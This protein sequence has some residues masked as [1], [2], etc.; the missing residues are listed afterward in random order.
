MSETTSFEYKIQ[1]DYYGDYYCLANE[2]PD[3]CC[4]GWNIEIDAAHLPH[5][6]ALVPELVEEVPFGKDRVRYRVRLNEHMLCPLLREDGLC[7]L[8]LSHGHD[9]TTQI[10]Q[11]FPRMKNDYENILQKTVV[12]RCAYVLELLWKKGIFK[13]EITDM[14]GL[15]AQVSFPVKEL[16]DGLLEIGNQTELTTAEFLAAIFDAFHKVHLRLEELTPCDESGYKEYGQELVDPANT[17]EV[18]DLVKSWSKPEAKKSIADSTADLS[19]FAA[20]TGAQ[21]S[22]I[23]PSS[24]MPSP[25]GRR[26][27]KAPG[28]AAPFS[29]QSQAFIKG[30]ETM[31]VY[32]DMMSEL[33]KS[34][35]DNPAFG[36]DFT[37]TLNRSKDMVKHV[38]EAQLKEF[39]SGDFISKDMDHKFMLMVLEELFNS[40]CSVEV[41][42]YQTML[43]RLQWLIVQYLVIRYTVF[44]DMQA[45]EEMTDDLLQFRISRIFRV[46]DLPDI[47]RVAYFD[48]GFKN[49]MWTPEHAKDLLKV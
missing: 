2:C 25:A 40:V 44:L 46:T 39:V 13:Y 27:L 10:C 24:I 28:I 45:G 15:P 38:T 20:L 11:D 37:K 9:K 49:W 23:M 3:T 18:L 6:Q 21:P 41:L 4:K 42:D 16:L 33:V 29:G 26:L 36:P 7:S 19:G 8:V 35:Y 48:T 17:K 43:V 32:Q 47:L 30:R 14:E 31:L 34:F 5:W 1:P 12:I 22:S